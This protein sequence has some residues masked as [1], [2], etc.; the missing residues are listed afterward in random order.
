MRRYYY[1]RWRY[2]PIW[3]WRKGGETREE[4]GAE[5]GELEEEVETGT[6]SITK[7]R[8]RGLTKQKAIT[9]F[10]FP[11]LLLG[12]LTVS[13]PKVNAQCIFP[14]IWNAT[15]YNGCPIDLVDETKRWCSTK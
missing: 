11:P 6:G 9:Y 1:W 5:I 4:A 8:S 7:V 15:S 3:R 10:G 12:C 14:F 2:A 13:G